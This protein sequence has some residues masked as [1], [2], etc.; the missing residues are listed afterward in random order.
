M[1]RYFRIAKA[2]LQLGVR[3][4]VLG[5]LI[6][7]ISHLGFET[8]HDDQEWTDYC[9][10]EGKDDLECREDEEWIEYCRME[11]KSNAE[12]HIGE[13]PKTAQELQTILHFF[14]HTTE[15]FIGGIAA[16]L[17][18]VWGLFRPIRRL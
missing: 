14:I 7:A 5:S 9:S 18:G 1:A 11:G 2:F 16:F 12:C 8:P 13:T 6:A 17:A 10:S 15:F 3:S 4:I